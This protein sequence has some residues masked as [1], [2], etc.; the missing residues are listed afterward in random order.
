M[1][2][3]FL[4]ASAARLLLILPLLIFTRP[5]LAC[6]DGTLTYNASTNIVEWCYQ[7]HFV[8]ADAGGVPDAGGTLRT[9]YIPAGTTSWTVPLDWNSASNTIEAVGAG[10]N[11]A[12]G[13]GTGGGGAGGGGGGSGGYA[14]IT[15]FS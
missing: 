10:G 12:Q 14:K 1:R 11:G 8:S 9:V 13:A 15:N 6:T 3:T 2:R 7:G 4:K 5:A